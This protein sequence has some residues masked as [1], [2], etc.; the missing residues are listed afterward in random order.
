MAPGSN[1][2]NVKSDV[3]SYS[4]DLT[5]N[6]SVIDNGAFDNDHELRSKDSAAFVSGISNIGDGKSGSDAVNAHGAA[7]EKAGGFIRS[8]EITYQRVFL[9]QQ[10]QRICL[11]NRFFD[12]EPDNM[13]LEDDASGRRENASFMAATKTTLRKETSSPSAGSVSRASSSS[14]SSLRLRVRRTSHAR[15]QTHHQPSS[16]DENNPSDDFVTSQPNPLRL[17]SFSHDAPTMSSSTASTTTSASER[18]PQLCVSSSSFDVIINDNNDSM[19]SSTFSAARPAPPPPSAVAC[20]GSPACPQSSSSRLSSAGPRLASPSSSDPS[21]V[22]DDAFT[23][24]DAFSVPCSSFTSS[25]HASNSLSPS[26]RSLSHSITRGPFSRSFDVSSSSLD[27]KLPQ[28]RRPLEAWNSG[29]SSSLKSTS[30]FSSTSLSTL[31][32][33]TKPCSS[34]PCDVSWRKL[35]MMVLLSLLRSS[36]FGASRKS[37][38]CSSSSSSCSSLSRSG[39]LPLLLL[40]QLPTML[41]LPATHAQT[42]SSIPTLLHSFPTL[43]D[44]LPGSRL[45]LNH[46]AV[47][48]DTGEKNVKTMTSNQ[49]IRTGDRM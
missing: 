36:F 19:F 7:F 33:S 18:I 24:D 9:Q 43:L 47:D 45:S 21:A 28:I 35:F 42:S 6:S 15:R 30:S 20:L 38:S 12:V 10:Q 32:M 44:G 16:L 49:I 4:S 17:D 14:S 25:C 27:G 46:L 23:D 41:Q 34:S 2:S 31:S 5:G 37:S 39:F 8:N 13:V 48:H 29:S 26:S 11:K 3:E 22:H 1:L 40:L